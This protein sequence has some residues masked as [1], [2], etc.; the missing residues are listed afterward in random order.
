LR[1]L[2]CR[3][4]LCLSLCVRCVLGALYVRNVIGSRD[5]PR[6]GSMTVCFVIVCLFAAV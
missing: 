6:N 2:F 4:P 1:L 5:I 3:M